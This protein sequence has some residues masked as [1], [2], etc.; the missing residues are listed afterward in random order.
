MS[1]ASYKHSSIISADL[2]MVE[3]FGTIAVGCAILKFAKLVMYDCLL[4]TFGDQLRLCFTD[5][6]SFAIHIES[7][8]LVGKLGVIADQW[9]DTSNF[10][11]MHPLYSSENF[12]R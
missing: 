5:T 9:L 1:K 11:P 6:D 8:D 12:A 10:E 7:E 4:P 2:A 3:K